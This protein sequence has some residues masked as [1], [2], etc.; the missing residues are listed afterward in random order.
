MRILF[1]LCVFF[2]FLPQIIKAE[3]LEFATYY[4]SPNGVFD[5]IEVKGQL[6]VGNITDSNTPGITSINDVQQ[7]QVYVTDR[8]I[9]GLQP[10]EPGLAISRPGQIF[11]NNATGVKKLEFFNG[12]WWRLG[13]P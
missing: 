6:I 4:P 8:L 12:T 10:A 1:I 2:T 5:R 11:F 3:S 13:P 9:F 7:D